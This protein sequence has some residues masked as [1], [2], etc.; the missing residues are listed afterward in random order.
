ML[1]FHDTPGEDGWCVTCNCMIVVHNLV[2][3]IIVRCV[4][5]YIR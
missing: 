5:P 1:E 3:Q 4:R 2:T